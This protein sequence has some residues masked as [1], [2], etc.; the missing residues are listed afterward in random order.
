MTGAEDRDRDRHEWDERYRR[1]GEDTPIFSGRP[2]GALV[3][4]VSGTSPGTVLE[5]GCGEGADAVWLAE[6]GWDV[7][8]ID[9]SAVALDRAEQAAAAAGVDGIVWRCTGLL[10]HD[11]GDGYDLVT[12]MYVALRGEPGAADA[13]ADAV[14]PGGT[15]VYV[16]HDM[17]GHDHDVEGGHDHEPFDPADYV[18]PA[19]VAARLGGR[20]EVLMDEVRPRPGPLP[21]EARHIADIV[22]IARRLRA[23]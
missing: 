12:A 20:F 15:L 13:L 7:T 22:L 10:D 16:H 9:P 2:N 14:A 4:A 17:A 6:Q 19:D 11:P 8:A 21:P 3:A 23:G 5:V 1:D 18:M